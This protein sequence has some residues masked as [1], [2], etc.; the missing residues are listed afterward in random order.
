MAHSILP[1][2]LQSLYVKSITFGGVD[3]L[4]DRLRLQSQTDDALLIVVG[5]RPGSLD[6]RVINAQQQLASNT[7][8]VLIHDNGLRYR[9]N[10]KF[11]TSDAAGRFQFE[12]VEPGETTS[13]LPGRALTVDRGMILASCLNTR[14][15]EFQSGSKK[16]EGR[17]QT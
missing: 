10:E 6:G 15:A 8:I 7:T 14:A 4:H 11:T 3:V 12:N 2:S 1:A 9:V 16:D 17:R 13:F 5:T